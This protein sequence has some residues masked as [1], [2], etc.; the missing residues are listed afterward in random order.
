VIK[1]KGYA[2]I[3]KRELCHINRIRKSHCCCQ[4]VGSK[5]SMQKRPVWRQ[6]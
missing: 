4:R 6:R 3:R 5:T 1:G 2:C